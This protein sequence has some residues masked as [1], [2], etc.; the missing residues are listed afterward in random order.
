MLGVLIFGYFLVMG[1]LYADRMFKEKDIYTR[2]WSGGMLGCVALMWGIIPFASLF[3]FSKLAHILLIVAFGA[4]YLIML[5]LKKPID[6][7]KKD[8]IKSA[9]SI[10]PEAP[11]MDHKVFLLVVLPIFAIISLLMYNHIMY[12]LP[13][14]G[15]SSGQST[16][17]DLAMH[18]G[19]ITSIAEQQTF[20]PMY[21]LLPGIKL[22]YPFLI[23]SLSSSLYLF[24]LALRWALLL[25]SF[26]FA[27]LLS[28][29]FTIFARTISGKTS[30]AVLSS[31]FFFLNGG[32]GFAYFFDGAKANPGNF[33][34]IFTEFYKTPTNLNEM[35]IRWA[36]TICDMIVPQRTTMAG[37]T[38]ILF[39]LWLLYMAVRNQK[40]SYFVLTGVIA[41]CMPMIHTHSFM[42]L[43]IISAVVLRTTI[44][45]QE[46]KAA[47]FKKWLIFGVI[48]TVMALPQLL[49][50]TFNQTSGNSGFLQSV[51][52]R[53]GGNWSSVYFWLNKNDP[54]WW[55][56]LKNWG[57]I[58]LFVIPAV[59]NTSR[60]NKKFFGGCIAIFIIAQVIIFQPN[61]YDNNKLFYVVFMFAVIFTAEYLIKLFGLMRASGRYLFNTTQGMPGQYFLAAVII[62]AC[63]LSGSLTIGRE[64]ASAGQYHT[65]DKNDLEVAEF[66][67]EKTPPRA[68]FATG[69]WHL[70]PVCVLSGR[71][72]FLGAGTFLG[73][74]GYGNEIGRRTPI[75]RSIFEAENAGALR[76]VAAQNNIIYMYVGPVEQSKFKIKEE[77]LSSLTKIY[78]KAGRRIYQIN[79]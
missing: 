29:G 38:V 58:A 79:P 46:N 71:N 48:A 52:K 16:Y 18:M 68:T 32:L 5:Y 1:Y 51:L 76:T 74:H 33:T 34:R 23:D 14:G 15:I 30:V 66:I 45:E 67:K 70:N 55:F 13:N 17:G 75:I 72:I 8:S 41:G 59:L 3:G 10:E 57:L 9:G 49:V 64:F 53:A 20:P 77:V 60:L 24:G 6:N 7:I 4:P 78:D 65:F 21:D 26:A 62:A 54:E 73:P 31:V 11:L 36:N 69:D 35:N 25:P 27:M 19:F 44:G 63:T 28:M 42:A 2:L 43:G 22:S 40:T 12:P 47:Y 61:D 37:W 56:W 39:A 50:W